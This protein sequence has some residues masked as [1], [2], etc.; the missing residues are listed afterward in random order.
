MNIYVYDCEVD[1]IDVDK[2]NI[3]EI[4]IR[5]NT[6][7]RYQ[8]RYMAWE[9]VGRAP[10]SFQKPIP[11]KRERCTF[12]SNMRQIVEW[13]NRDGPGL[14]VFLGYNVEGWDRPVLENN[15]DR[16][17]IEAPDWKFVDVA[18]IA[19]NL[20][21]PMGTTQTQLAQLLALNNQPNNAHRA[22]ADVKRCQ[23]IWARFIQECPLEEIQAAL[24]GEAP[25]EAV[26][27]LIRRCNP[28]VIAT[29][30]QVSI[31]R[32]ARAAFNVP[33]VPILVGMDTETTGI[34]K[35]T[36]HF[37]LPARVVQYGAKIFSPFGL[38]ESFQSLAK[39]GAHIHIPEE[40]TAVHG[41][42]D[43]MIA[44][45]PEMPEVW[46]QFETMVRTSETYRRLTEGREDNPQPR[47]VFVTYNG[48][49]FDIPVVTEELWKGDRDLKKELSRN[50][51]GHW[52]AMHF[53]MSWYAQFPRG[54]KP[55][56]YKLQTIRE[57]EGVEANNAHQALDDVVVL[58]QVLRK[59]FGPI[60]L[61]EIIL[62]T[63]DGSSPG[64][65]SKELLLS[66]QNKWAEGI[67]GEELYQIEPKPE[68]QKKSG[69]KRRRS[70]PEED[71]SLG[72]S[73]LS[74][75]QPVNWV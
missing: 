31:V 68:E 30:E 58:E 32:A 48:C 53:L 59:I 28:S 56:N 8:V 55:E 74:G 20:G 9:G 26:A 13:V 24:S 33:R 75:S 49:N 5:S 36:S 73:S 29:D 45:A 57:F 62:R 61:E 47:I 12:E 71:A 38:N 69:T 3:S 19:H 35:V 52:D 63:C 15:C 22:F 46:R 11:P 65:T 67:R 54:E 64:V 2:A 72:V 37:S 21:Y 66:A 34:G 70:Y 4:C 25:E 10:R 50:V 41:I 1:G 18:T 42:T 6:R 51:F 43:A 44:D 16:R 17:D 60:P 23:Q 27:A 39:P 40:A 7:N 14:K